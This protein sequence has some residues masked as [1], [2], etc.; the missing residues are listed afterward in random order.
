[1]EG[2]FR[3]LVQESHLDLKGIET[4]GFVWVICL[5][6]DSEDKH[7]LFDCKVL[8]AQVQSLADCV[9]IWIKR[10]IVQRD[11]CMAAILYP[12]AT[13]LG[14]GD[15]DEYL[16]KCL[17]K[18][19]SAPPSSE[20]IEEII[21]YP[22]DL[23]LSDL[24]KG[25]APLAI[26]GF[27]PL[28]L[29]LLAVVEPTSSSIQEGTAILPAIW[30]FDPLILPKP[31][32]GI[33]RVFGS[34]ALKAVLL[35]LV[36]INPKMFSIAPNLQTQ[37]GVIIRMSKPFPYEDNHRVPWKYNVS[38]ISTWTKKEEVCSNISSSISR[39]TRNGRCYTS[40]ELEKRRKEISKGT[41]ELVRNKVTTEEVEEF[42]KIIKNSEYSM[43]QQL[44]KL[45]AQIS[46]LA[47]LISSN[48][49][50]KALWKVLKET[51]VP[52]SATKSSF[53]GTVSMV[54]ATNQISFTDDELPPEGR[55]H[56]LPMHIM[57]KCEDMIVFRV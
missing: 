35:S 36:I 50:R 16:Q 57:V 39:L 23:R 44:K 42:L 28:V 51:C 19:S 30:G 14:Q 43:I 29:A 12:L 46:I 32:L 31:T 52:T 9:I 47:L 3:A 11:D 48:V 37:E 45:L 41:S 40:E 8:W 10:D 34:K 26:G 53:E 22:A 6:C 56:T 5:F 25:Q 15:W 49:H 1:M 20:V 55:E 4:P 13:Q 54:L 18:V 17:G 2:H 21:E 27:T 38:L 7:D 33:S 24:E